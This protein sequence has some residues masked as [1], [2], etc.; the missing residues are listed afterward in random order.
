MTYEITYVKDHEQHTIEWI[1]PSDWPQATVI[2]LW[3]QRHPT[4]E[5]LFI[6]LLQPQC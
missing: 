6:R 4:A 2:E 1:A 3:E 5:I